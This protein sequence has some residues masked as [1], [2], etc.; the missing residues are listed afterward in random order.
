VPILQLKDIR[1]S[2]GGPP[3][4]DGVNLVVERGERL[5]LLGRNG[6]GKSTLLEIMLGAR[7]PDGGE[8]IRPG[9]VR[10]A[11]L[12]QDV[13]AGA[14]GSVLDVVAGPRADDERDPARDQPAHAAISRVGLAAD[15]PFDALSAGMKRR[16]L[17]ARAL[18]CAPDLLLLDEPTNHL[19]LESIEW[20]EAFLP[21]QVDTLLFVTH[22][23]AL[24]RRL[25]TGILDLDRGRLTRHDP[26][27]E[28]Y[29]ERRHHAL[30]TETRAKRQFDSN[31][32]REES[33]IREG[34]RE[35]RKRN[36]GRVARLRAM[37]GERAVRRDPAGRVR[38]EAHTADAS[39][40]LVLR[41]RGLSFAR[42]G[43]DI[44]TD[45]ELDVARG[46]RIGIVGPNGSGKTTLLRLLLGELE[47]DRGQLRRGA[48]VEPAYFDQL[49]ARLDEDA[50]AAENV[51]EGNSTV[52]VNGKT[53]QVVSYLGDFLFDADQAR[54]PVRHFSGGERNRLLLA[55]IFARPSNLL[56]LDEPTNDLDVE[57]LETLEDLLVGYEGTVLLVS[58]DRELLDNVVTALIVLD[59]K[60]GW[61][62][63]AGGYGDWLARR[64]EDE[65]PRRSRKGK[66]R[67]PAP[68]PSLLDKAE[69]RELNALPER[70][71]A[72][73]ARR[74]ALHAEMAEP[75]FFKQD[76]AHIA[77]AQGTLEELDA[78]IEAAYARWEALEAKRTSA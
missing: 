47:P 64:A 14:D 25:A 36:M 76:G 5:A 51:A 34:V 41:A 39:G 15:A 4:L 40:R 66:K 27:Y 16:A 49:H 44:V 69:R 3:L 10:I 72:L 70:I 20:L 32:A 22:D 78:E 24:L 29:L 65:R 46:D 35:R 55:R 75:S 23:R 33:W 57:T 59:G 74:A 37:R 19:D 45:L 12:A 71:E 7:A 1:L 62:E 17:L 26:D 21:R 48:G 63:H 50:T 11:R 2:F 6:T 13:P 60:G 31:L 53:R 58:H 8:V 67:R 42:D 9:G 56:V 77:A 30:A 18:A 68:A 61:T 52:R 38:M 73:E 54:S 28:R 43:R